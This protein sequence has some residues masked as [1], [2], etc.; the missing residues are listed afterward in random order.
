AGTGG[1]VGLTVVLLSVRPAPEPV[2]VAFLVG[3]IVKLTC[4]AIST[5]S[6][7]PG[8]AVRPRL[9]PL[10]VRR[11]APFYGSAIA[12]FLYQRIDVLLLGSLAGVTL[13]GE[14]AAA[15]R[16]LDGTF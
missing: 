16:I 2:A 14:S 3:G 1:V 7:V 9:A 6:L 8:V 12:V 13:A 11:G 10:L 15:H 5:R 4:I